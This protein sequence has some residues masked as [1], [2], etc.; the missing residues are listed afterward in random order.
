[1]VQ[2]KFFSLGFSF[3][4]L[5]LAYPESLEPIFVMFWLRGFYLSPFQPLYSFIDFSLP[6]KFEWNPN[7]LSFWL[8]LVDFTPLFAKKSYFGLGVSKISV[9]N[10]DHLLV[11]AYPENLSQIQVDWVFGWFWEILPP[12]CQ[13]LIFG[14]GKVNIVVTNFD[15][16]LVLAYPENLSQIRVGWVFCWF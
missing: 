3:W 16:L 9:T 5:L 1:M 13:K 4:K 2:K 12:F 15:H 8:I 11:I 10:F 7:W 6:W 14:L